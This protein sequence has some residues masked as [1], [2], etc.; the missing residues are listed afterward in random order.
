MNDPENL[1]SN[2]TRLRLRWPL[3]GQLT[4]A[5]HQDESQQRWK[6]S[7][8]AAEI[9]GST[10]WKETRLLSAEGRTGSNGNL[11]E[12]EDGTM[13]PDLWTSSNLLKITFNLQTQTGERKKCMSEMRREK[14]KQKYEFGSFEK[15]RCSGRA[16]LLW[17]LDG[18]TGGVPQKLMQ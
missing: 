18:S 2:C 14:K 8:R 3:R 9:S 15:G 10:V 5:T 4:F 17:P 16:V 1:S 11:P 12:P 13:F 7:T 6:Q